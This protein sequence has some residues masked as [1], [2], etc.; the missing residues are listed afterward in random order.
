VQDLLDGSR[1]SGG[2]FN[3]EVGMVA[4]IKGTRGRI[5][6]IFRLVTV[7][8]VDV[9]VVVILH[10]LSIRSRVLFGM[11]YELLEASS[12]QGGH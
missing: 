12:S 10:R 8:G 11:I 5:F 4:C 7:S 2:Y 3:L 6:G 9:T 1:F